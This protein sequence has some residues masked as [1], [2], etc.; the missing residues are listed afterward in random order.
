MTTS[1]LKILAFEPF[2][3]GSHRSVRQSISQ[4]SRH[5][6]T[7][8]TRPGRAWKWRMRLAAIELIQQAHVQCAFDTPADLIFVTSLLSAADL[9]ALL[10]AELRSVPLVVYMHENQAAYPYSDRN[11]VDP[12][13]DVHFAL[14]N[15][16]TT[17]A[18][19]CVIFNSVYNRQSFLIGLKDILKNT[20]DLAAGNWLEQI[21]SK[22]HIAWPP[23]ELPPESFG[24]SSEGGRVLHNSIRVVWPHRWEHDKGVDEL[25]DIANQ[26]TEPLNLRWTILGEQFSKVPKALNE[27]RD[28]FAN[29]ID[30]I[31]FEPDRKKYWQHLRECDWVLST[32]KHEFFGIAV[33]EALLAGCLPWLP[34]RLSYPE[35]LPA[36]A[37]NLSPYDPPSDST[38]VLRD[39]AA[40]L[41]PAIA[42]NAVA[43]IDELLQQAVKA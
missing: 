34:D 21:E 12:K 14:T 16:T 17:L 38:R 29:Q 10:P 40:H 3:S 22:S 13:R 37:T 39:I 32:A 33:V 19:D 42:A 41:K 7:W 36:S 26:Y 8:L 31:G 35:L 25:L 24:Q 5:N 6:W 4:H 27:F 9:R 11:E 1:S 2:D 15:L 43:R 20:P 28:K 23:V 18:A 30:H